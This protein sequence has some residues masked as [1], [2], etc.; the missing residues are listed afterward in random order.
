MKKTSWIAAPFVVWMAIFTVVPL[1]MVCWYAFTDG[2]GAFTLENIKTIAVYADYLVDSLVMGAIATALCLLLGYPLAYIMSRASWGA[3]QTMM[4]ML[5]LPQWMNFLLRTYSWM[6]ILENKGLIN[7]FLG[8]F[9]IGPFQMINTKGAIILGMV[10]N[11]LPYMILPIYSVME[12]INGSLFEAA[13]DLGANKLNTFRRV[14]LPLSLP[15]IITGIT[16]VFVPS[17]STFVI[18]QMLGGGR[19]MLIGDVIERL[20]VGAAPNYNVGAALS[21]V[22]MVLILISMAVMKKFDDGEETGG[23]MM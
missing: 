19:N 1:G 11:F 9:G 22:L 7:T 3:Q 10:Y 13:M 21:L 5:M 17:V 18:S 2:S 16:M 15:G 12:K 6:T 14:V 23:L 8:N 4:L 20:F